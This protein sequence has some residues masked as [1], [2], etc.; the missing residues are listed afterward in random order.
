MHW[1]APCQQVRC[2]SVANR[3]LRFA[4]LLTVFTVG[5]QVAYAQ[6]VARGFAVYEAKCSGCHSVDANRIGPQHAGVLGRTIGSVKDFNYSVAL[7]KSGQSGQVWT[8]ALLTRW[9]KDP[10]ALIAGQTMGFR[11][12]NDKEIADVVAYLASLSR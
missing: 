8:A 1:D 4:W 7:Q 5:S 10:E 6:D 3:L 2:P 12:N 11:L 9:L